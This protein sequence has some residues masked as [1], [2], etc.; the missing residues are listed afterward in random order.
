MAPMV[1]LF[2]LPGA[3]RWTQPVRS[4]AAPG[5]IQLVYTSDAH[6]GL[7][8]T[9]F[10]G[11]RNVDAR[12]VNVALVRQ[13]NTVSGLRFPDDGGVRA[14]QAVGPVDFL[15]HTG[16]IANRSELGIQNA[17]D[18]W[19]QFQADYVDGLALRDASGRKTQVLIAPGNHDASNAVGFYRPMTPPTDDS[20]M[21]AIYNLM[22]RPA[23]LRTKRTYDYAVDRVHYSIDVRGV[24][25]AFTHIWPD[26]AERL[27][28]AS[29]LARVRAST[30]VLLFTHDEPP[31]ESKHFKNPNGSHGLNDQDRFE[32]LLAETFKDG[33]TINAP[34]SVEQRA[35]AAFV[36][37]HGNIKGYFHGNS[38]ANEYYT[39][40]GPDSD[41]ALNVYRVDSP[42]KGKQSG[43]DETR[44]SFQVITIDPQAMAMTVR[45]ALWNVVPGDP[46]APVRW[47]ASRTVAL[48]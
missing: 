24:H 42:M 17:T 4:S 23:T 18:S 13:I 25:L 9:T 45:E 41:V 7:K 11:S 35:F 8:R 38:N 14:G 40:R 44:L 37:A 16:D 20:A 22:M 1:G 2:L 48:R 28:L 31:V 5:L 36:K 15:V 39:W 12:A 46:Y 29:D 19:S 32:N 26:S 34:S 43:P 27:W 6:Y 30:P 33:A 10:R 3:A 47:G 21:V